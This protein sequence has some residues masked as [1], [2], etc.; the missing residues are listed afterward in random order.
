MAPA[1]M[2]YIVFE[3]WPDGSEHFIMQCKDLHLA[4]I[5]AHE[6]WL[7]LSRFDFKARVCLRCVDD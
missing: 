1:G 6:S 2:H 3:I 7:R 4:K 5:A